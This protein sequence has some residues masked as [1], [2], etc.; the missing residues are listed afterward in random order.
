VTVMTISERIPRPVVRRLPEYLACLQ[1]IKKAGRQWITSSDL[2]G[3]AGTSSSTVRQDISH[4]DLSGTGKCGYKIEVLQ[5]TIRR[6][7][8]LEQPTSVVIGGAG[9]LAHA[10]A[11]SFHRNSQY[12]AFT[13]AGIFDFDQRLVG[14]R[15]GKWVVRDVRRLPEAIHTKDVE[16]GI[17]ATIAARAQDMA[18]LFASAGVP[19]MLN[20]TPARVTAVD[21]SLLLD[22]STLIAFQKLVYGV[23]TGIKGRVF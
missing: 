1:A 17:I 18:D 10:L 13:M 3:A 2:A 12:P 9:A 23:R 7:L 15:V 6:A 20:L 5:Q 22:A 21:D 4:L 8:R 14:T 16:I 11:S 19:G